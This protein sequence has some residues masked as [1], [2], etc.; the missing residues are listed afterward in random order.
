MSEA[1]DFEL[2]VVTPAGPAWKGRVR[3]MSVMASD[4][5]LEVH[6]FHAPMVCALGEGPALLELGNEGR[7]ALAVFGGVL[8]VERARTLILSPRAEPARTI[9]GKAV[10]AALRELGEGLAKATPTEAVGLRRRLAEATIR[11][12]TLAARKVGA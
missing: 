10:E 3:W 7:E 9:D 1:A 11:H 5:L 4:G 12:E 6:P 2:E 8:H